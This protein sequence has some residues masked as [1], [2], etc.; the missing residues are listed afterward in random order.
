[1]QNKKQTNKNQW[2]QDLVWQKV[3]LWQCYEE[4]EPADVRKDT[5]T[6]AH[7]LR[8][9]Q[10]VSGN[11]AD[12]VTPLTWQWRRNEPLLPEPRTTK[13]QPTGNSQVFQSSTS[14]L[15]AW[16]GLRAI[17]DI[18]LNTVTNFQALRALWRLLPHAYEEWGLILQNFFR[19]IAEG[20]TFLRLGLIPRPVQTST[21]LFRELHRGSWQQD[22]KHR[23]RACHSRHWGPVPRVQ[24][25]WTWQNKK[26]H[27]YQ[28]I[29][30]RDKTQHLLTMKGPSERRRENFLN[31]MY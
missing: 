4:T 24:G 16:D 9:T 18:E 25:G 17:K 21:W 23:N 7:A 27:A 6:F 26:K 12:S 14:H 1:M 11:T 5:E 29:E 15:H 8:L 19:A 30:T 28:R 2:S 3:N 13:T 10:G 31:F 20:G 22:I